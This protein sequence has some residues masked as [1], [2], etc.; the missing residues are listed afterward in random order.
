MGQVGP[1]EWGGDK[2]SLGSDAR[3][4]N[5]ENEIVL[6]V[7]RLVAVSVSR[8]SVHSVGARQDLV[9]SVLLPSG[10]RTQ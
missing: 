3:V 9:S 1:W 4:A 5:A 2:L 7:S 8:Q 6:S 10:S